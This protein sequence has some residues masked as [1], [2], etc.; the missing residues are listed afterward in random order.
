MKGE[1]GFSRQSFRG[2]L[3]AVVVGSSLCIG[4]STAL[5][6]I[7][8]NLSGYADTDGAKTGRYGDTGLYLGPDFNFPTWDTGPFN[9]KNGYREFFNWRWD[10]V[11]MTI[12]DGNNDGGASAGDAIISGTMTRMV[13]V[14]DN[15]NR[16]WG[17]TMEL[18]NLKY[19]DSNGVIDVNPTY[20][21][22]IINDLSTNPEGS[23]GYGYE[24]MTLA[25]TLTP[26][27]G[28]SGGVDPTGWIGLAMPN[29]GHHNVAELHF[30]SNR[31]VTF[32]AWYSNPTTSNKTWYNV[33]DTKADVDLIVVPVPS[34]AG[35]GLLALGG[36]G[37]FN[38][39]RKSRRNA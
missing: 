38:Y 16:Q 12:F 14:M 7:T 9:S 32:E 5:A 36:L 24:W 8:L 4:L 19:K 27:P 31:G 29:L 21:D 20:D 11:K 37:L 35:L 33:G 22:Q 6:D 1:E 34:A 23:T 2:L 39:S 3:A 17:I 26:Y 30:D 15:V 28:Y 18:S 25:L 13:D 10:D